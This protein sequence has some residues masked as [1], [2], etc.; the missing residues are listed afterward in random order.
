MLVRESDMLI[1]VRKSGNADGA[2]GH[3]LLCRGL[4]K[5]FSATELVEMGTKLSL[6]SGR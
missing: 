1:V 5:H 3:E 2:K 4:K 6:L